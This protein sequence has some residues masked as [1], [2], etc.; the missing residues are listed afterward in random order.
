VVVATGEWAAQRNA[1]TPDE[2]VDL[3]EMLRT[4]E[5]GA[6]LLQILSEPRPA[7]VR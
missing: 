4:V 5:D 1:L 7:L 2:Q 3:D 6:A